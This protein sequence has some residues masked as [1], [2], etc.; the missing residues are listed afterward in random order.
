[1]ASPLPFSARA[2]PLSAR[3]GL[4]LLDVS[5][6]GSCACVVCGCM[7]V[8][9]LGLVRRHARLCPLS[10]LHTLTHARTHAHAHTHPSILLLSFSLSKPGYPDS[11]AT[12]TIGRCRA[13]GTKRLQ[14]ALVPGRPDSIRV[15]RRKRSDLSLRYIGAVPLDACGYHSNDTAS[16]PAPQASAHTKGAAALAPSSSRANCC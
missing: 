3:S 9:G 5:R 4:L 11:G 8:R 10:L 2:A 12:G 14:S 1:M 6:R 15:V 13:G 7:C 16:S